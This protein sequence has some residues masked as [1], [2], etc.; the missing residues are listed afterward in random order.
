MSQP[1]SQVELEAPAE[2]APVVRPGRRATQYQ[3]NQDTEQ[4][5]HAALPA[6][7]MASSFLNIAPYPSRRIA[8][9]HPGQRA[10]ALDLGQ[11]ALP[12]KFA[13]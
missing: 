7:T 11:D 4:A 13:R 2:A 1:R 12:V 10:N 9:L 8:S 5:V 6:W 3:R